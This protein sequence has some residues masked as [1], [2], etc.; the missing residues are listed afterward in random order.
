M[1]ASK[2]ERVSENSQKKFENENSIRIMS[3]TGDCENTQ[4]IDKIENAER[5]KIKFPSRKVE[6]D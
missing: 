4:Q 1:S 6:S 2:L 5:G 3:E